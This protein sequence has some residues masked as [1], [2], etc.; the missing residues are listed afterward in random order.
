MAFW[1]D[2]VV[3]ASVLAKWVS[4]LG[5]RAALAR[6]AHLFCDLGVRYE[7]AGMGTRSRYPLAATQAHLADLM[8]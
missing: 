3:D 1:R 6:L 7:E 4:T 5:R 8:G 2:T